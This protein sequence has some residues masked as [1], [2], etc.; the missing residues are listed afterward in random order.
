MAVSKSADRLIVQYLDWQ[1]EK[2]RAA[3]SEDGRVFIK[4]PFTRADGHAVEIEVCILKDGAVRFTDA[5]ET[6]DELWMQGI[7]LSGA[8]LENA[9]RIARRFRVDLSVNDSVLGNVGDGGARQFQDIVS[10]ILAISALVEHP[11]DAS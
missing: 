2:L 3:D 6:L 7:T 5:G 8:A 9:Q 10:A 1:A 4:T 11:R